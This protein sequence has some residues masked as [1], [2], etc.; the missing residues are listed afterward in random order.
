MA[1]LQ[2]SFYKVAAFLALIDVTD[3]F[4]N[5][6]VDGKTKTVKALLEAG[7]NVHTQEDEA[8]RW[9]ALKGH[10]ENVKA[11]IEAGADVHAENDQAQR[12][13]EFYG[14]TGTAQVLK[15]A[16]RPRGSN[17]SSDSFG[18]YSAVPAL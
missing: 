17:C 7:A 5:A 8:L 16:A 15:E 2:A 11:I 6:S 12:W 10:T 1:S 4:V 13:A 9:A 14:H 3:E 18:R